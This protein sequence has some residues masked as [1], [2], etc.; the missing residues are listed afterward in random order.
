MYWVPS[1]KWGEVLGSVPK[2]I[3]NIYIYI[4]I[5]IIFFIYLYVNQ[6]WCQEEEH[7]DILEGEYI[8]QEGNFI[9]RLLQETIIKVIMKLMVKFVIK[10]IIKSFM[11]KIVMFY[12]LAKYVLLETH[13]IYI[14]WNNLFGASK[15]VSFIH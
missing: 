7:R 1:S 10:S 11:K 13:Q 5:Y 3:P 15:L 8:N 2:C 9:L 6:R 4:Y 14:M 12:R